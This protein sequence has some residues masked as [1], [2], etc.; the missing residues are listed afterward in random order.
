MNK[1]LALI[2]FVS[3]LF[4]CTTDRD[5]EI[6]S[7][8]AP[9]DPT[10][11]L[12][13]YW[14]F[15]DISSLETLIAPTQTTGGALM[16]YEGDRFDDVD[17][18]ILLNARNNDIEGDALR[19]RNPSGNFTVD[20]PTNGYEDAI[21]T[22]AAKR[23]GSGAQQ[24][25]FFYTTDGTTFTQAGLEN[26]SYG[27]TETYVLRQFDFTNIPE[28]DNNPNFKIRIEFNINA[29]GST[30][31]SRFDNFTLDAVP[32]V[33]AAGQSEL[34]HYWDFNDDTD[35]ITLITPNV[36]DGSLSYFGATFD[37][38]NGSDL[39]ARNLADAG[40]G[41]RLRN[42][43]ADFIMN[44]PTTGRKNIEVKFAITRSGSGSQ[45][46]NI[47]YTTDGTTYTDAG[48]SLSN[49]LI[50]ESYELREFDFT[51]IAGVDNNPNFKVKLTF[52]QT[53][54]TAT[55]GNS[56]FD[57]L[58]VEGEVDNS[59]PQASNSQFELFQ[60][61]NFNDDTD[62]VTLITPNVGNGVLEYNGASFDDVG[63]SDINARN[64]D[65]DGRALRL[66][67]PSGDFI[68]NLPSTGYKNLSLKFAVTRS[69]SGSQTFD[70]AYTVD[71]TN[72]IDTGISPTTY[73]VIEDYELREFDLSSITDVN[74]NANFK[75]RITFDAISAAAT[76]G[77]SRFDNLSLEGDSL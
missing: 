21:V 52:D 32:T 25:T 15:N 36:G 44:I 66:R 70:I 24:Q 7:I 11:E 35:L 75:V 73:T 41:L 46:F 59:T 19:L 77:N 68:M 13:H 18:S 14:N 33:D 61:W 72:Y 6:D 30:G 43:S 58:S 37:D 55:S 26:T 29:D 67:N 17:D 57:N 8:T 71:G 45:D 76:S 53:S 22:Y 65:A 47:S 42:P 20:L 16:T 31:N 69:G 5:F 51:G 50:I 48:L 10:F 38:V 28:A 64:M 40:K 27:V 49:F 2:A 3:I 56:R 23:S 74:N 34:F 39:N 1:Y 12:V 60:Y 63:G 4:A 9:E 62:L 54:S